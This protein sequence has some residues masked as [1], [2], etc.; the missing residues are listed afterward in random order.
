MSSRNR[1][2]CKEPLFRGVVVPVNVIRGCGGGFFLSRDDD[3][4]C[5]LAVFSLVENVSSLSGGLLLSNRYSKW[6]FFM[7]FRCVSASVVS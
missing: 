7:Y 2:L 3:D 5:K 6:Y 4:D 1:S